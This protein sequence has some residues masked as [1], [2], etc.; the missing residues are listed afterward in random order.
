MSV[1]VRDVAENK[2]YAF[3]KG[4]AEKI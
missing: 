4:A 2:F 3:V 1:L